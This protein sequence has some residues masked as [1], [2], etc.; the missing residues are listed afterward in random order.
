MR[1][2]ALKSKLRTYDIQ[3]SVAYMVT[4][5]LS[6]G[7][8]LN[9]EYSDATLTNALPN[10]SAQLPDGEQALEGDGWDLGWSAGVQYRSGPLTLGAS[11]K[12]SV[13]RNLDGELT[14]SGLL[15]PLEGQNRVVETGATF[16]TPWHAMIGARYAMT[17]QLTLNTQVNRIG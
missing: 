11:Y 17:Q 9:I 3:P 5:E 13:K 7:A 8:A 16:R 6:V 15:G 10:L 12:S 14:Q 4:P 1:Y 2:T